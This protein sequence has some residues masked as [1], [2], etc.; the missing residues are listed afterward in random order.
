MRSIS[1]TVAA[2]HLMKG[3]GSH[4]L[5]PAIKEGL[6]KVQALKNLF[7]IADY[8]RIDIALPE[9]VTINSIIDFGSC[10]RAK[11]V[12]IKATNSDNISKVYCLIMSEGD[13]G[14][15]WIQENFTKLEEIHA[16]HPPIF[17]KPYPWGQFKESKTPI[18]FLLHELTPQAAAFTLWEENR[19][20]NWVSGHQKYTNEKPSII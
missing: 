8:S 12:G 3:D 20:K 9:G 15:A 18:Y 10:S 19:K 11:I 6:S 4:L 2:R 1:P 13:T 17:P 14:K 5:D 7:A 16:A